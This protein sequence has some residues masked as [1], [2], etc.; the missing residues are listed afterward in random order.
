MKTILFFN[1]KGGVGKTTLA[2]N[3]VS[4]MNIHLGKR[5]LLVDA[6]PQCNTTQM[7]LNDDICN[8]IYMEDS[9]KYQTLY[10]ILEPLESGEPNIFADISP[11]LGTKNNF[12]T[13]I[14]PG[15]PKVSVIEDILSDAWGKLRARDIGGLRVTNWCHHLTTAFEGRYDYIVFDVGPSLGALNRSIL[16]ESDYIITPF[17]CDIFS[18]LGIKNISSWVENWNKTY[19][20]TIDDLLED[21]KEEQL[22]KYSII[23][24]TSS[25]FRFAGFSIQQY[26][27]RKFKVGPRPV[28]AYENVMKQIPG[29][30][31]ETMRPYFVNTNIDDLTLGNIPYLNSL[32]PLSQTSK[33]P[34]HKLSGATGIV[35]Q[36]SKQVKE[37][38]EIL[39]VICRK[40][41]K[42]VGDE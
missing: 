25:K 40:I 38:N 19:N 11:I 9:S 5:V 33:T 12:G 2:C 31:E 16:L 28:K 3:L 23:K 20:K 18:L 10:S 32:V 22:D 34:M 6:D 39:D 1:N 37:Y 7:I 26:I 29:I 17:G 14:I 24:D 15:H 35:G 21:G 36:Q 41:L 4:Y 8:E 42:N 13:D 30:V 27:Q